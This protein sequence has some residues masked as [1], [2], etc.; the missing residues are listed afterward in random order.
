TMTRPFRFAVQGR[1]FD[2]AEALR[3]HARRVESLG[4]DDLYSYDHTGT[5]AET[6]ATDLVDP[7]VP[8]IVAAEATERLRIGPLVLN[9]EFHQPVLLARTAAT[10]DRMTGGRLVLGIGT[11][12]DENE[13]DAIGSP[14]R[15]PGARV[16]R[17]AE[18]LQVLRSLLDTGT[19]DVDGEHEQVHV[20]GLG[21]RP[22]QEH[23]PF[24]IGGHGRRVVGLAGRFADI[25]QFT[26]LTHGERGAPSG[27]G[28]ALADL[29][30]RSRWLEEA[31][32]DRHDDIERS[33]LVQFTHLG[34]DAPTAQDLSDR[35]HL[36]ADI[37]E[38]APFALFG[39]LE[40]VVDEIERHR[41][42]LGITHYV[43]RDADG[44]APVVA[45]LTGR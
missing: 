20:G 14:I 4:Y 7:F 5:A 2:D 38:D 8:L 19:A 27:G 45:A 37:I 29:V 6:D 1:S 11:G 33:A 16:T 22:I 41:E 36:P 24:L 32:G 31:A 34:N 25:F 43:V 44:F 12:Y 35:F 39:S 21:V 15:P 13:H 28:F 17:F 30:E 10:V 9:N 40:R 18:S 23:V 26:G 42:T 3:E